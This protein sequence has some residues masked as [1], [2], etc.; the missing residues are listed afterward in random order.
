MTIYLMILVQSERNYDEGEY[1]QGYSSQETLDGHEQ[2]YSSDE[3]IDEEGKEQDEDQDQH[4]DQELDQ[5][6]EL[7]QAKAG[8]G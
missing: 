3:T 7:E 5:D 8:K 6:Q 4:Q 1:E 2:G